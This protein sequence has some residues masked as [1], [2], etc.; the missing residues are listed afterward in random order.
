MGNQ[1]LRAVIF[2]VDG[3]LVD[4][5]R[6]GH[7]VAFNQAFAERGMPDRWDE[8]LYGKLLEVAGGE[9]R[10]RHYLSGK[11]DAD[12]DQAGV[13]IDKLAAELHERKTAIFTEMVRSPQIPARPGAERLIDELDAAGVTVGVATT[14][15][16]EWVQPLLDRLFGADRFATVVTG[17]EAPNRKPDP[18]AYLMALENLGVDS[19]VAVAIEDSGNGVQAAAAARLPCAVV[20]NGYTKLDTIGDAQLVLDGFGEPGKP[21]AVLSDPYQACPEGILDVESLRRLV[22]RV[23]GETP[24]SQ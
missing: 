4:T 16:T 18:S 20:C 7:R 1:G 11:A 24:P 5:E 9:R 2:D 6:H 17:A 12:G 23:G 21:A 3:T 22:C 14:G 10:I 15:S 13:D 8:D 19:A